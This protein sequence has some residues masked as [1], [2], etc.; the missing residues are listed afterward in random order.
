M[1]APFLIGRLL[2]G[3]FFLY[4]GVNH[5]RSRAQL[6]P[7]AESKGVPKPKLAVTLSAIPLLVGGASLILGVKPKIGALAVLSFLASVSPMMHNFWRDEDPN[8]RMNNMINFT[9]NAALAGGALALLGVEEPWEASV[10]VG[11]PTFVQK[12]R[13]L[14]RQLAA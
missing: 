13:R 6:A 12:V 9:K 1:K 14:G 10:P 8:E 7:Y 11:Q 3:G 2:F 5:I 4:N